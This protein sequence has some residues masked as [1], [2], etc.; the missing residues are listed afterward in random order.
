MCLFG[1][2]TFRRAERYCA[3]APKPWAFL[4]R[5]LAISRL[6]IRKCSRG[7]FCT[8]TIAAHF[9]LD[10]ETGLPTTSR[11]A[12]CP[13]VCSA[14][15]CLPVAVGFL[16]LLWGVEPSAFDFFL[17]ARGALLLSS[18]YQGGVVMSQEIGSMSMVRIS[19]RKS[20]ATVFVSWKK[21]PQFNIQI[22]GQRQG[23][24][25]KCAL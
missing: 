16:Q 10:L 22:S 20:R 13:A 23:G 15:P 5:R 6:A 25:G 8:I 11:F 14:P 24:A 17:I 2:S 9:V 18:D 19:K 12:A 3:S 4:Y 7:E 21:T 1:I